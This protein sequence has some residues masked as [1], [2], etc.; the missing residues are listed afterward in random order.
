MIPRLLA[1]LLHAAAMFALAPLLAG[2]VETCRARLL[3]KR[4]IPLLAG[5]RALRDQAREV[6]L[7]P[8]TATELYPFWPLADFAAVAAAALLVP[9]FALGLGFAGLGDLVTLIGLFAL[10]Q[11]VTLLAGLETGGGASGSG[12]IRQVWSGAIAYPALLLVAMSLVLLVGDPTVDGVAQSLTLGTAG[13]SPSLALA[14]A[15]LGAVALAELASTEAQ[16]AREAMLQ[17]YSGRYLALF[18]YTASLRLIVWASLLAALILPFGIA[19]ASQVLS[20][21]LGFILW[22]AKLAAF[23]AILALG[24]VACRGMGMFRQHELLR[25]G[26]LLGLLAGLL[27]FARQ[28]F[29]G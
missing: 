11:A 1:T 21:P 7:V 12:A 4:A 25:A 10:A 26:V 14:L 19:Q 20:W 8:E 17:E 28:R 29:G 27:L 3:G 23:G 6:P 24:Q 15:G 5:Y 16:A 9:G 18:R 2:F 13:M 22:L